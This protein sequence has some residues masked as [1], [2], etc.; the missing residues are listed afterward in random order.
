[1][2]VGS[3]HNPDVPRAGRLDQVL[4]GHGAQRHRAFADPAP[5]GID[6]GNDE[7]PAEVAAL[8]GPAAGAGLERAVQLGDLFG[9][10]PLGPAGYIG[11]YLPDRIRL[12]LEYRLTVEQVHDCPSEVARPGQGR[13]SP[14]PAHLHRA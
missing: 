13:A 1:M 5:P 9:D 7:G 6:E 4:E 2:D 14:V 12:G 11:P 8:L 3:L 10:I